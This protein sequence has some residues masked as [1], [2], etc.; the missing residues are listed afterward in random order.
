MEKLLRAVADKDI[1]MV[2][3]YFTHVPPI[4]NAFKHQTTDTFLLLLL[5]C[6]QPISYI[7]CIHKLYVLSFQVRYLLEW[8]DEEPEEDDTAEMPDKTELC[9]PLCQCPNCEPTQKVRT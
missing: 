6:F 9:H 1:E 8:L 7:L 5:G 4:L 2:S 3:H